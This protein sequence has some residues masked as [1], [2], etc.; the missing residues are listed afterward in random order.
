MEEE[1]EKIKNH[2]NAS[3]LDMKKIKYAI[4]S[5]IYKVLELDVMGASLQVSQEQLSRQAAEIER[6]RHEL[7][8]L[9][10]AL[11][12]GVDIHQYKGQRSWA[13]VCVAGKS[14]YIRL[15]DFPEQGAEDIRQIGRAH[16]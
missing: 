6:L 15:F 9:R 7:F 4:F 8:A 13:I 16:V 10:S 2:L 3:S 1:M 14:E 12:V 11:D 5:W